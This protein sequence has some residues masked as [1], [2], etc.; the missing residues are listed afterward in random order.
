MLVKIVGKNKRSCWTEIWKNYADVALNIV[1][2]GDNDI[3]YVKYL[4][5]KQAYH[6]KHNSERQKQA[7]QL[8]IT[9][10]VTCHYIAVTRFSALFAD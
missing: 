6:S 8:M 7:I 2:G 10:S 4:G 5:I 3:E 9:D 1:C